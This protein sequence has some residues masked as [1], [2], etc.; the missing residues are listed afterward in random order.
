MVCKSIAFDLL[1]RW[2]RKTFF[3]IHKDYDMIS[4]SQNIK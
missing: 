3:Q 1:T 4:S 2:K